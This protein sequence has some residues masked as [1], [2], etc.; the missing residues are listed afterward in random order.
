MLSDMRS[1]TLK[2]SLPALGALG[3]CALA[4]FAAQSA[5]ASAASVSANWAGYVALPAAHGG[6]RFMSV[7]G[8]WREPSATCGSRKES[9]SAVWVGL[10]GYRESSRGLEQVGTDADCTQTGAPMYS[11]WFE[12]LPAEPVNLKL[13]VHPGDEMVASVTIERHDVTLRIRDLT[14]G[15]HFS[16][17]KRTDDID[18]SSAEWIV[19]APSECVNEQT[20]SVLPLTDFGQVSFSSATAIAD[21]HTGEISDPRWSATALE[22][23]QAASSGARGRASHRVAPTRTLTAAVPSAGVG[24]GGA[25]SVSWSQ[26]SVQLKRRTPTT[27]PGFGG[28]P[29]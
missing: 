28:G 3:C 13:A 19:E 16:V 11:S 1:W 6:S 21:A 26:Q 2:R 7:S 4:S 14:T 20:C 15:G 23:Q 25:F 9:D 29:P 10:G 18:A 22:L 8:A 17:T 12:L 24:P 27:L 5:A